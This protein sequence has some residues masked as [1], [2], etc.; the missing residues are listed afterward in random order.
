M[1]GCIARPAHCVEEGEDAA[2]VIQMKVRDE[3]FIQPGWMHA[4]GEQVPNR[5]ATHI[6]DKDVT[7]PQLD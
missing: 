7:V 3:D 6:E 4:Q 5:S 1:E 2:D